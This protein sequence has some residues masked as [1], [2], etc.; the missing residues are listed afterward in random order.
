MLNTNTPSA[1]VGPSVPTGVPDLAERGG[2][3]TTIN[4]LLDYVIQLRDR[5]DDVTLDG[6]ENESI[7]WPWLS[8]RKAFLGA[9]YLG[10][11]RRAEC[12]EDSSIGRR[13]ARRKLKELIRRIEKRLS[14]ITNVPDSTTANRGNEQEADVKR[15][16]RPSPDSQ[17]VIK[18]KHNT[19]N[20][21]ASPPVPKPKRSTESGEARAK[22]IPALTKH[23]NY[24][25]DGPLNMTF[26]G[27]NELARLAG[28]DKSSAS[29]FFTKEFG[30]HA[31]YKSHF[32]KNAALLHASLKH[33]N[34]EYTPHCLF[35]SKPP[36]E[37]E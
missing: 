31:K 37:G 19:I 14:T 28:V 33:L 6:E 25:G 26:I 35:G 4:D 30:G 32:C 17:K 3:P 1:G 27:N 11:A 20:T 8:V 21:S 16:A 29:V 36:G 2:L 7:L 22:L 24:A 9:L 15:P 10:L 12:L 34:N 23:H 5:L 13:G 18:K